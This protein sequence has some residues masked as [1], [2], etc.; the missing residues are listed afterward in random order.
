[1]TFGSKHKLNEQQVYHRNTDTDTEQQQAIRQ[2]AHYH[3]ISALVQF[4]QMCKRHYIIRRNRMLPPYGTVQH[5]HTEVCDFSE[6]IGHTGSN[7]QLFCRLLTEQS[8]SEEQKNSVR[9]AKESA[10][11]TE[12]YRKPL[13]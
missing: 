5:S 8:L 6:F 3:L 9:I 2:T 13:Q 10:N 11:R 4:I 12:Y 1:M 7:I